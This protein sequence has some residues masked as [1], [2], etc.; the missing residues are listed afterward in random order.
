[1]YLYFDLPPTNHL[2]SIWHAKKKR[3]QL[4]KPASLSRFKLVN[5][6]K[7]CQLPKFASLSRLWSDKNKKRRSF[8]FPIFLVS[9]ILGDAE[10]QPIYFCC[11]PYSRHM[12]LN[13]T[14]TH[15][16]VSLLLYYSTYE[17]LSWQFRIHVIVIIISVT[18]AI[19]R[20]HYID[21]VK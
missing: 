9:V 19:A 14:W 15:R 13:K 20:V 4:Q 18:I 12:K 10:W 6:K 2:V 11:H 17:C 1:M 3:R 16:I 7:R 21:L 5:K 8:P